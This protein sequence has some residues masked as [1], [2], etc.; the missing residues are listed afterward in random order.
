[1]GAP[2]FSRGELD[3]S[4]AEKSSIFKE[5]ALALGFLET[6]AKAHD[7]VQLSPGALKRSSPRLNAGAPTKE[8]SASPALTDLLQQI[9]FLQILQFPSLLLTQTLKPAPFNP[10]RL[11]LAHS[12]RSNSAGSTAK[13]RRAGIQVA[14]MPISVMVTTAPARTSGSRGVAW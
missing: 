2:C 9:F 3:F 12:S 10:H 6:S 5:W 14:T 7:Q 8:S 4:P 11:R 1:V 13:A